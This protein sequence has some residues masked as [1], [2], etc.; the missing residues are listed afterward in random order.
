MNANLILAVLGAKR[1]TDMLAVLDPQI[2]A[3]KDVATVLTEYA[4][5]ELRREIM[6]RLRHLDLQQLQKVAEA[7]YE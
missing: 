7:A 3:G 1:A 5:N 6:T 2:I 4:E